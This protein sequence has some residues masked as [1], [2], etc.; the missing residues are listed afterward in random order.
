MKKWP[1]SFIVISTITIAIPPPTL[2][3][4]PRLIFREKHRRQYRRKQKQERDQDQ[5]QNPEHE[6]RSDTGGSQSLITTHLC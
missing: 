1:R 3:A 6:A 4:H 5:D 2:K